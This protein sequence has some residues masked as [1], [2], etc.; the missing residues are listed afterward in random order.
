M[1]KQTVSRTRGIGYAVVAMTALAAFSCKSAF[2]TATME[3]YVSEVDGSQQPYGL[4]L[5]EPWDPEV[6]H[7]VVIDLH[8]YTERANTSFSMGSYANANA[9][10]M[11][12]PDG[13]GD[14]WYD[15]VAENDVFRVLE[16]VRAR[17]LIDENRVYLTGCSMGGTGT[18]L[19]GFRHPDVF[20]AVSGI[21]GPWDYRWHH[22]AH[23][24]KASDPDRI[25]PSREPLLQSMSAVDI[26]ENGKN[27]NMQVMVHTGDGLVSPDQNARRLDARLNELGYVHS[28]L[29]YPGGHCAGGTTLDTCDFFLQHAREPYPKDVLLKANQLKYGSAYWVRIDRLQKKPA[30]DELAT[31]EAKITGKQ[32]D[33]VEVTAS[34][35]V[36]FT[37]FLTPELVTVDEVN[38]VVNG[39]A[40][41][42]GPVR[43]ITVFASLD[44]AGD[45]IGWSTEDTFP[46]GLCKTALIEGPIGR[47][48]TSKFFLVVGTASKPDTSKNRQEAEKFASEW[49]TWMHAS[50]SPV[51][52]SF[53]TE[54]DIATSNLILFGTAD[55]NS[56][57]QEINDLLPVRIWNDRIVAGATE[58]V[59]ENYGLYMIFPNPLNPERY[60]VISH[61]T[62]EG[63][64]E[65]EMNALPWY[66]P[67]YVVFDTSI[68]PS[69][70]VTAPSWFGPQMVYLPDAW[71]EAGFFDQ[72]WRLDEDEDNMDDIF[73]KT[74]IDADP[75]DEIAAIG[76]VNPTDD[77]DGDGQDNCTEYNAGTDARDLESF[78]AVQSAG[79]DPADGANFEV[80]W[81]VAAGRSY[82]ILWSD[83]AD[84]P[85]HEIA[86]LDA[87]DVE[88]NGD[89]RTWTDR[90]TDPAMGGMKPGDCPA[91]FYKLAAYR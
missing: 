90:G 59:G 44:E 84:G 33:I 61:G 64:C 69:P 80:S 18:F 89:M 34:D 86:E 35:L 28:Y 47:A 46:H 17:Y 31:I 43:Q 65:T 41:Y 52:D 76:D 24:A 6:P 22:R 63:S 55:S 85:W 60:V 19:L 14:T 23:Y 2:A 29:E 9:W 49:N 40:V 3:S 54:E 48:N 57:I 25:E 73:E 5:P 79:P 75:E 42:T 21:D 74:I 30:T 39:E 67:D 62:I 53:I 87:G 15:G 70:T 11:V 7:P 36:Q 78:L 77:F 58:Y 51:D 32:K 71:V 45:I 88:D 16:E 4:Y 10:I 8:G 83:T 1:M 12:K 68:V 38:I 50:I 81:K 20:A 82:Y 66:W 26:A 37:L 13:R 91:R 72:Y 56:V 27:L